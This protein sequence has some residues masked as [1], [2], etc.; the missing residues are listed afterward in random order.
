M[1][2]YVRAYLPG[3]SFFFTVVTQQRRHVFSDDSTVDVLRNVVQEVRQ[4]LPFTVDAWV[5]LP[6][7]IHAVWT[8]PEG[9]ADFSKRWGLIKATF[10]KRVVAAG[11]VDAGVPPFSLWQPR[12]WEHRIRDEGD[13]AAS[14]AYAYINPVRHGLVES[15][16]DWPWSSFHRDVQRR[17]YP[18]NWGS[19][20]NVDQSRQYGE[21][22]DS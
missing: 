21:P 4:R 13:F 19:E 17:M 22:N 8:L 1:P 18:A 7:H 6:N 10:T 20:I 3:G 12:F 14:I 2:N 15:V 9:D 16:A 5:V 11:L